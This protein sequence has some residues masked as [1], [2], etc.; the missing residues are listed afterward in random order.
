M[1]KVFK[2]IDFNLYVLNQKEV[3]QGMKRKKCLYRLPRILSILF[4][5]FVTMF[6]AAS[7]WNG[8]LD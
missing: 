7:F 1:K 3:L 6:V 4:A 5:L 2:V 8:N